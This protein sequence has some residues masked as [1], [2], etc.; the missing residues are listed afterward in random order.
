MRKLRA[1]KSE[2]SKEGIGTMTFGWRW[3]KKVSWKIA[4]DKNV[5][6]CTSSTEQVSDCF[7]ETKIGFFFYFCS[8]D[9]TAEGLEDFHED[10]CS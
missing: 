7:E 10:L 6:F 9:M 8:F 4:P 5:V 2:G 1:V 3:G